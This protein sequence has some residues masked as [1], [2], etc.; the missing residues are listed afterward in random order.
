MNVQS[1]LIGRGN[2]AL[3]HG[4]CIPSDAGGPGNGDPIITY[5]RV[6]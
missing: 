6:A 2:T 3:N 5:G 4:G 1:S